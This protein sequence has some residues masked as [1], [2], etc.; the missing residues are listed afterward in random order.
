MTGYRLI[1]LNGPDGPNEWPLRAQGRTVVGRQD[2]TTA[3][4]DVDLS[5]DRTV[6]RHHAQIWFERDT[7]WIRDLNSKHGTKVGKRRIPSD[8]AVRCE[9]GLDIWLGATELAIFSPDWHRVR[10]DAVAIEIGL[11]PRFSYALALSGIQVVTR[12]VVRNWGTT[13]TPASRLELTLTDIG[14]ASVSVPRLAPNESATLTPLSFAL[15]ERAL[16]HAPHR[17]RRPLVVRLN[18]QRVDTGSLGCTLLAHNEWAY[19]IHHRSS[20]GAFVLPDHPRVIN[21]TREATAGLPL[22]PSGAGVLQWVYEH[23]AR[24]WRIDYRKDRPP[25]KGM[26]QTLR[27]A[28]DVLWDPTK[29]IGEGTCIDLA[30]LMTACL[31]VMRARPLLAL[32][33]RDR[34]WHALVGCWRSPRRRL[35][36]FP[37]ER[38]T[39]LEEAIWVDPNGCTR[40]PKHRAEFFDACERARR[41]LE[42][43]PL[44]FALDVAAARAAGIQPLPLGRGPIVS[45]G[46]RLLSRRGWLRSQ[47]GS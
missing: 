37:N 16:L 14:S 30:L 46:R 39:M 10:H 26:T 44:V 4:A 23:L 47:G 35:V 19:D 8:T 27:L 12:L 11:S 33:D 5:P 36:T 22:Q 32:V 2:T 20:L 13:T 6:S 1:R 17:A 9:P 25:A 40:D 15:D 42:E 29:R 21:T 18:G 43:R 34:S 41:D 31:E 28:P 24:V 38:D 7:W 3:A 45:D